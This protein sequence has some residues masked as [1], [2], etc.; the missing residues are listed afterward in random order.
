MH[1]NEFMVNKIYDICTEN[2]NN[3]PQESWDDLNMEINQYLVEHDIDEQ[4]NCKEI[5]IIQDDEREKLTHIVTLLFNEYP[6]IQS[7]FDENRSTFKFPRLD[8]IGIIRRWC[9]EFAN[10]EI[11]ENNGETGETDES[12]YEELDEL[13]E[14]EELEE[15]NAYSEYITIRYFEGIFRTIYEIFEEYLAYN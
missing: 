4:I 2:I 11:A 3:I 13:E 1:I 9:E 5:F 15:E 6:L 8:M 12:D 7:F 14:C 10:N